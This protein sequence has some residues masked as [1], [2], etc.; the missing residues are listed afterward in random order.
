[1]RARG[2]LTFESAR[3]GANVE[4]IVHARQDRVTTYETKVDGYTLLNANLTWRP[5]GKDG[6]L[7]LI[8]SGENL[9]DKVGRLATSETRDFVP[10][11]GRDIRLTATLKI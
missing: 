8:L 3:F 1:M 6:A 10:I 4:A 7:A 11:A 9:L 5:L 2:G